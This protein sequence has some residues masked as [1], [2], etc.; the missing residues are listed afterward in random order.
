MEDGCP[1]Q[2]QRRSD[3]VNYVSNEV[4]ASLSFFVSVTSVSQWPRNMVMGAFCVPASASSGDF[5]SVRVAGY[6]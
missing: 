1:L 4:S 6:I 5:I 2:S 3:K